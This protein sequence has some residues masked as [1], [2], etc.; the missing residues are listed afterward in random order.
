MYIARE[1]GDERSDKVISHGYLPF[2]CSRRKLEC[3][4]VRIV[5]ENFVFIGAFPG[6]EILLNKRADVFWRCL[7]RCN[8]HTC[9]FSTLRLRR[10]WGNCIPVGDSQRDSSGKLGRSCHLT[11]TTPASSKQTRGYRRMRLANCY[12]A[13]PNRLSGQPRPPISWKR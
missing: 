5:G 12:F 13:S 3:D 11:R 10:R 4:I 6:I 2:E 8:L 9:S 1:R 7:S